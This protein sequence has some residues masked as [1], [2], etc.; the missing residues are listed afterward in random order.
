VEDWDEE[1]RKK[2][3]PVM[4]ALLLQKYTGLVFHDPE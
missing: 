2:N 3:D 4:E 1:A